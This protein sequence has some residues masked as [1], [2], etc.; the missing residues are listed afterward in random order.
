M[1]ERE[2]VCNEEGNESGQETPQKKRKGVVEERGKGQ[3]GESQGTSRGDMR[4]HRPAHKRRIQC[5]P[6]AH[7]WQPKACNR[8]LHP[9]TTPT[10]LPAVTG[11]DKSFSQFSD[12]RKFSDGIA[13]G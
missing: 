8:C 11:S 7:S 1:C 3:A 13:L 6:T 5:Q 9:K 4:L 12:E 10:P 2:D